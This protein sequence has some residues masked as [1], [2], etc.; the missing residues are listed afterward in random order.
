[1]NPSRLVVSDSESLLCECNPAGS[2]GRCADRDPQQHHVWPP[3][4]RPPGDRARLRRVR[5]HLPHG[6]GRLRSAVRRRVTH[7]AERRAAIVRAPRHLSLSSFPSFVTVPLQSSTLIPPFLFLPPVSVVLTLVS[8][9][10]ACTKPFTFVSFLHLL[11]FISF[12][13]CLSYQAPLFPL[14]LVHIDPS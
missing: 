12:L 1:M 8:N 9:N 3:Q 7:E 6:G 2:G 5:P 14:V 4:V 11:C 10:S 13:I